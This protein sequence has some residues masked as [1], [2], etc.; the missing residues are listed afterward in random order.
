M[1]RS[2][3]FKSSYSADNPACVEV[4][5]TADATHV[6][7]SKHP[8]GPRLSFSR[9]TWAKFLDRPTTG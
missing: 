4:R 5:L 9:T 8:S 3:W 6:R 1:T 7:D 2:G